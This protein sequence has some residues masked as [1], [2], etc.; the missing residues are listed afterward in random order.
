M[1]LTR[2][3]IRV[4][5]GAV[6]PAFLG[7]AD[8]DWLEALLERASSRVNAPWREF[9]ADM[10]RPVREGLSPLRQGLAATVLGRLYRR[11]IE[12]ELPP[13]QVRAMVFSLAAAGDPRQRVIATAAGRLQL[14]ES[15]VE[16]ALFADL[17]SERVVIPPA[18]VPGAAELAVEANLAM[19]RSL[20][21]RAIEVEIE[22]GGRADAL[23]RRAQRR[24]LLWTVLCKAP[25]SACLRLSGPLRLFRRTTRYGHALGSLLPGLA[26]CERFDLVATLAL[27]EREV[28]L[29]LRT[30]DLILPVGRAEGGRRSLDLGRLLEGDDWMVVRD[31]VPIEVGARFLFPDV[32]V[33]SRR[34]SRLRWLIE[35]VGFWTPE[36]IE[37]RRQAYGEAGIVR[38]ILC[39]D[40]RLQCGE[41]D[42]PRGDNIVAHRGRVPM[43]AIWRIVNG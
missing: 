18:V 3:P 15:S 35:S 21:M 42:I 41:G 12:A 33:V 38:L 34:D 40:E 2:L 23:I 16:R 22:V 27:G 24:G 36:F 32:E 10:K 7:E 8:Y 6:L 31:P 11:R 20:L 28:E 4:R 1:H 9:E 39:V 25:G 26:D 5:D 17:P 43:E 13:P 37:E 30:G 19:C 29:R 14:D